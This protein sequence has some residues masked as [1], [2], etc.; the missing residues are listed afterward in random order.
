MFVQHGAFGR[1]PGRDLHQFG[2]PGQIARQM[3]AVAIDPAVKTA[4]TPTCIPVEVAPFLRDPSLGAVGLMP[5]GA[6]R[7]KETAI[8][9]HDVAGA[10]GVHRLRRRAHKLSTTA[11]TVGATRW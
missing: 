8:H 10:G 1:A 3:Q 6:T 11:A 7:P 2:K 4:L 9:H 5:D